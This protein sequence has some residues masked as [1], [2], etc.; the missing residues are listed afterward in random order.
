MNIDGGRTTSR[1]LIAAAMLLMIG[2]TATAAGSVSSDAAGRTSTAVSVGNVEDV[3]RDQLDACGVPGGA[4]VVVSG[5]Q[6]EARGVGS[7]GDSREVTS[8]TPFVIGSTTKSFTALAVMQL[9]DSGDV[10]L[11]AP[12]RDYV[13]EFRLA[14][15]EPVGDITV[16]HLMQQTSG[17]S[18]LAGGPLLASSAEGTALEAIAELEGAEL[19]TRPGETWLYANANYVLAGLV[20]ERASGLSYPDYVQS[21][22]FDPLGMADSHVTVDNADG[23]SQG[24]RFWFGFPI[25]TGPTHRTGVVA[26]GYLIS[27]AEDLGRYLSMYLAGGISAD[28]VRI[29]SAEAIRTMLTAGPDAHLGSW[30]GGAAA[31][32]GM[33]WFVGG[34]WSEDGFFHPGNSPDSSAMIA[35]FPDRDLAV[36]TLVNASHESPVPGNPSITD[37]VSRNVIHAALGQPVP[38]LPS[39]WRFYLVFD[40]IVLVLIVPAG[41]G[42]VRALMATHRRSPQVRRARRWTGVVVRTLGAVVLAVVPVLSIG[43]RG[44]WTWAPDLALV[45]T[46]LIVLLAM[47][48]AL[49]LLAL[50]LPDRKPAS[51]NLTTTERK[52]AHVLTGD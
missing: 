34:P 37:R 49:H 26:A 15:G 13:P 51:A 29:V 41:W 25:A 11:D 52:P 10:D 4:F 27:T 24:H 7:A 28:G 22:V 23:L 47:T 18:D 1:L 5:G 39:L 33:G 17:L 46:A 2:A 12:V 9:V 45:A 31:H 43:W 19:E 16:R 21:R 8:R 40:L 44:A 42:L 30:A 14:R 50:V 32:Y 20:V 38:D 3:L 48:A 36:A 6:V 35:L